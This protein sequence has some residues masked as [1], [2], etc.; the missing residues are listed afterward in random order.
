MSESKTLQAKLASAETITSL[1]ST[2][3][4]MVVDE[5]GKPKQISR[6]NLINNGGQ[7]VVNVECGTGVWIRILKLA[8]PAMGLVCLDNRYTYTTPRP[9]AFVLA[10]SS[11]LPQSKSA[12]IIESSIFTKARV[13]SQGQETGGFLE[14]FAKSLRANE[15]LNISVAGYGLEPLDSVTAGSIPSGWNSLEFDLSTVVG[16]VIP[17]LSINYAILQKGG[18][19]DG[20]EQGYYQRLLEV[21]DG[22]CGSGQRRML[23][24]RYMFISRCISML[25]FYITQTCGRARLRTPNCDKSSK[26]YQSGVSKCIIQ[27]ENFL[28]TDLGRHRNPLQSLEGIV[29]RK[30]V[31]A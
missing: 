29:T 21:E 18:L 20:R 22:G 2:D 19:R 17:N 13:I 9:V 14:V 23:G 6:N 30:E 24:Y 10:Y 3:K 25:A 15:R 7:R 8:S 12:T 31:A 11:H 1:A 26:L 4:L 27:P 16:G 28:K 5:N